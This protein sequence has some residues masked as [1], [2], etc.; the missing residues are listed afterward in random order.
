MQPA[1]EALL[2]ANG[3]RRN[4]NDLPLGFH[5]V[6][7]CNRLSKYNVSGRRPGGSK[8]VS[9]G[10]DEPTANGIFKMR[11]IETK[12][13]AGATG[14]KSLDLIGFDVDRSVPGELKFFLIN[15]RPPVDA[16]QNFLDASAVGVNGTV[17][18]FRYQ[19]G[20]KHMSHLKTIAHSNVY[21]ANNVALAGNGAFLLTNDHSSKGM[22]WE[23]HIS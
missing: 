22:Y 19:K 7:E 2:V 13:Y 20:S 1:L 3:T 6:N 9:I 18:V 12:G 17:E 10:I 11:S 16:Q 5:E 21:S 15:H 23:Y 8:L 14:D 4:V